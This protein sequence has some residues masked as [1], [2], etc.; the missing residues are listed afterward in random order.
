MAHL[1]SPAVSICDARNLRL[2]RL[3]ECMIPT[4]NRFHTWRKLWL[5][6]AIAEKELGLPISD[7]AIEQMKANLV[8][9]IL[10]FLYACAKQ[11]LR[12]LCTQHLNAE[13]FEIAAAEEKKRRHDVMAHVHTFG[14]VAPAAAGII[15]SVSHESL[16][17]P[18]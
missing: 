2:P 3:T 13:Q 15:Q 18:P 16:A 14:Q 6:L 1:F 17:D 8:R 9:S 4:Q 12:T 11:F 5:N 7:E 10:F